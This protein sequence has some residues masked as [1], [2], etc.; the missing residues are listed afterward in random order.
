M[1]SLA[2]LTLIVAL[3]AMQLAPAAT[4]S[5]RPLEQ[6]AADLM[7][8]MS[9]E[10]RIGQL[11]LVTLRGSSLGAANPILDLLA[12]HNISG[13]VLL[14]SNDNFVDT[15]N[16]LSQA[17]ALIS[18][19]QRA[20]HQASLPPT[21]EAGG[22]TQTPERVYV[23]LLIGISQEG[24]GPPFSQ[25]R[26]GLSQLPS[27]MAIGATWDAG[28]ARS[29]GELL[30]RELEALGINLVLGP[31][32]DVLQDPRQIGQG[33][34]GVRSFGGDPYWA[35]VMGGAFIEGLHS[36]SGGR[37]GVVAKHFPGLGGS[38]RPIEEEVST[39]RKSLVQ[40]QQIELAPFI[41][42]TGA[43]PGARAGIAD[44]LLTGQIRY[45]GFQGNIRDTTRP[46][47]FDPD[48]FAQLM[49]VEPFASWREGG[50][51]TVSGAL[52]SRAVR[53]F[54]ESLGQG[55][56][57]QL[58]ARDAFLAGNDLLYLSSNF[59]SDGDPDTES[60]VR[61]TLEFFAQKYRDDQVFAERVDQAVGRILEL[62]LRLYGGTFS[63]ERVIPPEV[64]MEGV[65]L[66][67][68]LNLDAARRA[69][70]LLS[71][72]LEEIPALLGG[73]PRIGERVV[74]ISDVRV[75]QQCSTCEGTQTIGRTVM[76]DTV[77]RLYGTRAA[78]Q[79]GAWN[80]TSLSMADVAVFLGESPPSAP[81]YSILA[82]E[83]VDE[84]LRP[85]DWLVFLIQK[86]EATA[87]G[88][89]ALKLL[90]DQRPEL[91]R[92]KKVVVFALDVPYDLDA[93]EISKIDVYYALYGKTSPFIEVAA[94]LLFEEISATGASPV[95]VPGIGYDLLRVTS[96]DP[97]QLIS[98]SILGQG[99]EPRGYV[100]GDVVEASTGVLLDLNSHPV[101]DGT[102]VEFILSYQ[103]DPLTFSMERTTVAGVA[104]AP[105]TLER[106][107]VLTI[108]AESEPARTSE[109]LQLNI[110][111]GVVTVIAPTPQAS[112]TPEPTQTL[113]PQT[114]TPSA[115]EE[116]LPGPGRGKATAGAAH[117]GLGI[118]GVGLVAS[119]G[120]FAFGPQVGNMRVRRLLLI[121]VGGLAL[122]DYVAVNLPGSGALL[123]EWGAWG[124]LALGIAGGLLGLGAS[125]LWVWLAERADG[126]N[127]E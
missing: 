27:A 66:G 16:T 28:L 90:L 34:L 109:I 53:R 103:G 49:A 106:L 89:D 117:L 29:A 47:G 73:P 124:G 123:Q 108:R 82:P 39:V 121:L 85:A 70:T 5:A 111:E 63:L 6:A 30:G 3:G 54:Y 100:A 110:Q 64:R 67:A 99:A 56:R 77:K 126:G 43:A 102:P 125:W 14:A 52:G 61:S 1:R 98:V 97:D 119:V 87:F 37:L 68:Q 26:S 20:N 7:S 23:P 45:Q 12:N 50:G 18:E 33:D 46:I 55:Y 60:T 93:T 19:L 22:A 79:V 105:V 4:A 80:L 94:R 57:G 75:D 72:S 118:V 71:P 114:V 96:P 40:L 44:G 21:P 10:E 122:Y 38:D 35:G 13:V 83:Q 48:A 88:S 84:L 58:V 51:I 9:P 65:G 101:P 42:V 112:V 120:Y 76:E 69:A 2:A 91:V 36:G 41:A 59:R 11:V 115:D 25:I 107:G 86:S 15:P 74:F 116:L 8:R 31:S 17:T 95:S 113:P 32:L 81:R 104:I 62:K 78:G 24:N 127:Q 92:D